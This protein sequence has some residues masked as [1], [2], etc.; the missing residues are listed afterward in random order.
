MITIIL[1]FLLLGLVIAVAGYFLTKCV[2]QIAEQTGLGKLF[3]G[4]LLL[5]ASTSLPELMVD[6]KAIQLNMPD[7]AVGDLLGSSLVNLLIIS[8]L[9]FTFPSAFKRTAFSPAFL[10]HSLAALLAIFLTAIVGIGI[11]THLSS[12]LF[13]L[14]VISWAILISYAFGFR[15]IFLNSMAPQEGLPPHQTDKKKLLIASCGYIISSLV[16]LMV[17]PYFV[18]LADELATKSGMGYTFIGTT[19]VALTTSLPELVSTIAA[20]RMGSPDLAIGNIFGSNAFNILLFIP[21]DM[22]SPGII[23]NSVASIH[24]VSAFSIVAC[25]TMAVMGMTYRRRE[26]SR[27]AEP[28]SEMIVFLIL[29]FLFMLYNTKTT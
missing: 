28:S 5:A 9:D 12:T 21:L 10:H 15:L 2:D 20:F 3:V 13:G 16:L 24:S 29:I 6:L 22:M 27:F 14:S 4:S 7:I 1:Q 25:M 18:K 23:Y 26:K 17:A 11:S 19:L 8:V